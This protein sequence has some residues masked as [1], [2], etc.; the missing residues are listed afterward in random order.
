MRS[1]KARMFS[2]DVYDYSIRGMY[3]ET[4]PMSFYK[5]ADYHVQIS[6]ELVHRLV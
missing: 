1:L 4:I 2:H 5:Y 6:D 3:D